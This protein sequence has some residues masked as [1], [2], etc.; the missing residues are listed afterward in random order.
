MRGRN[1]MQLIEESFKEM[2]DLY[3]C[4]DNDGSIFNNYD[5]ENFKGNVII[6]N[7]DYNDNKDDSYGY[8][9]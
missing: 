9:G 2:W 7:L 6:M 8:I 3:H 5:N 1:Q 4:D